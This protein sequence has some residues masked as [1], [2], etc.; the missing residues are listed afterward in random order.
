KKKGIK[1][2]GNKNLIDK[3][4]V[5]FSA[6]TFEHL[7]NPLEDLFF[8]KS[9]LSKDGILILVLPREFQKDSSLNPDKRNYHLYSWN[10]RT[11]NN[12]LDRA[13]FEVLQN[14]VYYGTGFRKLKFLSLFSF[15][16]YDF[17]IRAIG[18]LA[19]S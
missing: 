7:D 16:L 14:K 9:K 11:I 3:F 8:I 13:G 10:F 15:G 4:D 2:I 17:F 19:N 12:L 18:Y 6:H 1:V 5:I